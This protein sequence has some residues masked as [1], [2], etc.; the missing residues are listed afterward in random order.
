MNEFINIVL[1]LVFGAIIGLEREWRDK[2]AGLRT[3]ICIS[4][5]SAM[6]TV[7]SYR[8]GG[9]S[10]A[11]R[12][13]ANIVTGVG[14]LGAGVLLK[15]GTRITGL[16]TASLVWLTAAVGM[17]CGSGNIDIAI[18]VTLLTVVV[19]WILPLLEHWIDDLSET[20]KYQLDWKL[21]DF[22]PQ[23][24][25]E[26]YSGLKLYHNFS[27]IGKTENHI[28][29]SVFTKGCKTQHD[30]LL[31]KFVASEAVQEFTY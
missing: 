25:D 27:I 2:A 5:G 31:A 3:L 17:A 26:L 8:I 28:I 13:A 16:T 14:F 21:K 11:T 24:L 15:E 1:A 6:F 10:D 19:M 7:L 20:R 23:A 18:I 22:S 12:I 9:A 4:V 29:I 30:L